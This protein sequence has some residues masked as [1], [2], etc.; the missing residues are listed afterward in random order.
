MA[1]HRLTDAELVADLEQ[2]VTTDEMRDGF[3]TI[4]E[5]QT[6]M[7][8]E[9]QAVR[10]RIKAALREGRCEVR[11]VPGVDYRGIACTNTVYRLK[12]QDSAA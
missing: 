12:S 10:R 2:A 5:L 7:G 1:A 8:R 6:V 11:R 9:A 3:Y 4:E